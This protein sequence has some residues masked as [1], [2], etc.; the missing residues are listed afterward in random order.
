MNSLARRLSLLLPFCGFIFPSV[1]HAHVGVGCTHGMQNGLLHPLTGLDHI[2]AM[3]AVG[4][5]AAQR[6][7]RSTWIIPLS[8]VAA[9][10]V[11]SY[12]GMIGVTLPF[13]EQSIIV[14]VL[15]LG[16]M[17]AAAVRLPLFASALMASV[18]AIVHGHAHG[19]E[20]PHTVS[21]LAYGAGFLLS[22]VALHGIGIF[23]ARMVSYAN[24]QQLV[25]IAG[26]AIALCGL[27][28]CFA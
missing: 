18:F 22:T 2:C 20:M 4:L 26:G 11:G 28:L 12:L 27:C 23:A 15:V 10:T 6:G 7:G 8:F 21:G 3:V 13:V 5:W 17:V 14:S 1:A 25:R 19:A 9:M 24:Q 16:V